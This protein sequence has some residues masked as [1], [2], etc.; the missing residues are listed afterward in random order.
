M[1]L[2]DK[3]ICTG[4][5]ACYSICPTE[6]ISMKQD[7][8]G[9]LFPVIDEKKCIKCGKCEK[10]CPAIVQG[11]EREPLN[12]YAAKNL[13]EEIRSQSSSGGMFTLIAE[14]IISEGDVV[15]GIFTFFGEDKEFTTERIRIHNAFYE[16]ANNI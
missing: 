1:K 9:F 4:C 12:V 16:L 15:N 14:N 7:G 8:E 6:C 11:K 3:Q 2:A 5:A 13:N 10:A